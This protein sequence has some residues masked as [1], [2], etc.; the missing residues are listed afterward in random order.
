MANVHPWFGNVAIDNAAQWTM[1]FF[2]TQDVDVANQVP[3][4]PQMSIAETGEYCCYPREKP[5]LR[6]G[7]RLAHG[8]AGSYLSGVNYD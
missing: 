8:K 6:I 3:N 5:L 1:T 7:I 2:Q 4:K